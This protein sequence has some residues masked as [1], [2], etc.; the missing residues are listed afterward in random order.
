MNSATI[1]TLLVLATLFLILS[2][3]GYGLFYLLFDQQSGQRMLRS[4]SIRIGLSML[5]FL[6]LLVA[7]Y[8]GWVTPAPPALY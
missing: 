5:L 8:F 2:S 6:S 1:V 4:L 3:L 7:I